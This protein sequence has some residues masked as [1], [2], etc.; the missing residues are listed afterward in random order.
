[1][2]I[3]HF[4][5]D[6]L[7][8]PYA[9]GQA[10]RTYEINKRLAKRH[11]IVVVTAGFRGLRNETIDGIRY[12]RT[13][14]LRHP[15]N[16]LWYFAELLPRALLS[17]ADLF[18]ED[19]SSPFTASGLPTILRRPV[20][21]VASYLF[22]KQAAQRYR[23]PLDRWEAAV[24]S[25]YR[26][27]ISLTAAQR[28][29]LRS[30]APAADIRIIPNGA[31]DDAVQHPWV[32]DE[33]YIAFIGRLDWRMKGLDILLD[34]ASELPDYLPLKIAGD[35]PGRDWLK[36]QIES[37]GLR[38]RVQMLGHLEGRQRHRFLARAKVM[39]FSSRYENQSLVGLDA[40]AI[41]VPVIAFDVPSSR[42]LFSDA[43][44]LI[45]PFKARA[46]AHALVDLAAD[47]VRA[48]RLS[49]LARARG[50]EFTWSKSALAQEQFFAEVLASAR[51]RRERGG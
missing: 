34:A 4:D 41:G 25:R 30:Y 13:L 44:V 26:Y 12:V 15:A 42:E 19:F 28:Q 18:V 27:L 51:E 24:V 10:R 22:G 23:V 2:R 39:A 33:S 38:A 37:R 43:A 50:G 1:M 16:F 8:T 21:G 31:D 20:V 45:E 46:F 11:D 9:G 36:R 48:R 6:S 17:R 3:V 35:G 32:G 14:P 7:G 49:S 47:T 5:A 40:L 29:L